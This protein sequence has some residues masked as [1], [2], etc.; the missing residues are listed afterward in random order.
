MYKDMW[1]LRRGFSRSYVLEAPFLSEAVGPAVKP[2]PAVE[3]NS[4][5]VLSWVTLR[6]FSICDPMLLLIK[7]PLG[8][9]KE[10]SAFYIFASFLADLLGR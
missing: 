1:R 2:A 6:N 9:T 4:S 7:R 3:I 5:K 10:V 8:S